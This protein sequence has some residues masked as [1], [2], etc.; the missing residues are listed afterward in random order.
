MKKVF[1]F[2]VTIILPLTLLA[3]LT[4][5][6]IDTARFREAYASFIVQQDII[7]DGKLNETVWQTGNWQSDFIQRNPNDGIPETYTTKFCVLYD[8]EY[9]YIGARAYDPEPQKIVA[10]LSRRDDYTQSDW[11]YVSIDSYND[12]RTAFEFGLNAAGVK[13]DIR[14]FDDE[15]IDWE[16]DAVWDGSSYIDQDGWSAEWRIPFRELRFSSDNDMQW[17]FQVYRELP[18]HD[19]ELS[20][21]SYWAQS[22]EGFV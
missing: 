20:V 6:E 18:R 19:N 9:L 15:N 13:H 21:W 12:N 22:E 2:A 4:K 16:W 8:D 10:I 5:E 3:K 17:G 1:I 7:I 14:R 11:L